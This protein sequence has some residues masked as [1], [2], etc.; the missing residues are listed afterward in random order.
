MSINLRFSL[1]CQL[2]IQAI[3][4]V[5]SS[6]AYAY[7]I[8]DLQVGLTGGLQ[9]VYDDNIT[10][11]ESNKRAD[12]STTASLGIRALAEGKL[13]S[14]GFTGNFA[15]SHFHRYSRYDNHSQDFSV[16]YNQELD[17]YNRFRVSDSFSHDYE[18]RSFEDAFGR[19]S[20][21]YSI[22]NN[23]FKFDYSKDF[24]R[25]FA[26]IFEYANNNTHYSRADLTDS[27]LNTLGFTGQYA[28][29]SKLLALGSYAYSRRGFEGGGFTAGNLLTAGLRNYFTSRLYL[30][31]VT[32]LNFL[33]DIT[34]K[35][36]NKPVFSLLLTDVL[37]EVSTTRCGFR[38]EYNSVSYQEDLF[39]YWEFFADFSR[40][41]TARLG[42][43]FSGFY[44]QGEYLNNSI[45]DTLKGASC[46]L[47]YDLTQRW[48]GDL[49]Y[50]YSITDSNEASRE[51]RKNTV[52][53][54]LR[55]DL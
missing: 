16:F 1:V 36:Y 49:T 51:Y 34:G 23:R 18:P 28:I 48:K 29:N 11:A 55:M 37:D 13:R 50:S 47:T 53:F 35:R 43:T 17:K 19:S 9:Q 31:A 6:Q 10:Y 5:L 26:G 54:G 8:G 39:N 3:F 52:I 41:L 45:K 46:G 42:Y 7:K 40:R 38:R 44:G 30:D 32:G 25:R 21:R 27:N 12:Y 20:G 33:R 24:T 15:F 4:F 2:A 14:A 22:Y